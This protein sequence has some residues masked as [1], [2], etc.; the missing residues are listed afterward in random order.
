[1]SVTSGVCTDAAGHASVSSA[2]G[3]TGIP[4]T[5]VERPSEAPHP[6]SSPAP[7]TTARA[8]PILRL[9]IAFTPCMLPM[10]SDSRSPTP[11]RQ[12]RHLPVRLA[13]LATIG[14]T[15]FAAL[16][17][18]AA[19]VETHDPACAA[20]HLPPETAFVAR[21]AAPTPVDLASAHARLPAP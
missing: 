17:G 20:C 15:A 19:T 21:A 2:P 6:T 16:T 4:G 10:T 13:R 11:A 12:R 8:H 3:Y 1:M 5:F 9:I 7:N 18:I 14:L